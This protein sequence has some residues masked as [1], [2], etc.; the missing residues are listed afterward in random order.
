M[1]VEALLTEPVTI[2]NFSTTTRDEYNAPRPATPV[3]TDTFGWLEQLAT[4][5]VVRDRDTIVA[6]WQL[7]LPAGSA[8]TPYSQV[9][10]RGRTFTVH[11]LPNELRTPRGA[12]HIAVLLKVNQ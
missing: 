12:H 2:I 4:D 7:V 11:G 3:E 1:S 10:G 8:I 6:D 9:R 5:E